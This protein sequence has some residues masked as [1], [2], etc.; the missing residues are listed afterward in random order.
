MIQNTKETIAHLTAANSFSWPQVKI[1]IS[2]GVNC[3]TNMSSKLKTGKY[4]NT[5][6][7]ISEHLS[8][9]YFLNIVIW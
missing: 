6:Q 8:L 1:K 3:A 5:V 2:Q 7:V 4:H 9:F